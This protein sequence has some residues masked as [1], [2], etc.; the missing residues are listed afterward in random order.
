MDE[1]LVWEAPEFEYH[2]KGPSWYW[3]TTLVAVLLVAFAVYQKNYGFAIFIVLCEVMLLVWAGKEPRMVTFR[4][5]DQELH[6]EDIKTWPLASVHEFSITECIHED[7][8]RV[9]LKHNRGIISET[10]IIIPTE[11][12]LHVRARLGEKITEV[13][14]EDN[15]TDVIG[16]LLRF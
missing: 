12:V 15:W 13:H 10:V 6:A 5:T 16:R 4:L 3:I 1:H 14:H 9:F 8:S 2:D 11:L 7:H